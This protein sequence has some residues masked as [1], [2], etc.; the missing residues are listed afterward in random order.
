MLMAEDPQLGTAHT[1]FGS[2]KF[3]QIVGV[4]TEEL[5]TAQH[6]NGP[7]VLEILKRLPG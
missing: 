2:V 5:Q 6:W 7:G 3:V 1:P 4:C